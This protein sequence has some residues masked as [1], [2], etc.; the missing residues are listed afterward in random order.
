LRKLSVRSDP[1]GLRALRALSAYPFPGETPDDVAQIAGQLQN[2][3][4]ATIDDKLTALTLRG[5][6]PGA[7]EDSLIQAARDLFAPGDPNALV[8]IGR[9][10]INQGKN[11]AVLKLID[12]NT[13]LTRRDLFLIRLD[14]LAGVGNWQAVDDVLNGK[15]LPIPEELHLLFEFRA[16]TE[17]GHP[18]RA[19]LAWEKV[20]DKVEDNPAKLR[21]VADYAMKLNLDEFARPA[22]QKLTEDPAQRRTAFEQL[23]SLERRAH[24]TQALHDVLTD[25]QRIYIDDPVVANDL[26]YTGFLLGDATPDKIAE[27]Q[28]LSDHPP[29]MLSYKVTLALGYLTAH[30]PAAAAKVFSDLPT[31]IDWTTQYNAWRAVEIGILRANGRLTE[32]DALDKTI[33]VPDL[34][35]EERLLLDTPVPEKP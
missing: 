19:D 5:M 24:N 8:D 12:A 15:D 11:A 2:H 17:L 20:R 10:L 14:A 1:L 9:W 27:A 31:A 28:K 18:E 34:L 29:I 32:A 6:L 22:L 16:Q 13:A 7:N 4:L 23:V 21:D 33:N 3:P 25:M 26:L 35:P 30:D